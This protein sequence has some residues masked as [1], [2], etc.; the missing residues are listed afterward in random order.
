MTENKIVK[1]ALLGNFDPLQKVFTFSS[2]LNQFSKTP[3]ALEN[4]QEISKTT[5]F[6]IKQ[7]GIKLLQSTLE[8]Y[9][10][11]NHSYFLKNPDKTPVNSIRETSSQI[12]IRNCIDLSIQL[13]TI[14][15]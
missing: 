11:I 3:E 8:E 10:K 9:E 12:Q 13:F 2:R 7:I 4:N 6:N 14:T 5:T 1:Q 15:V